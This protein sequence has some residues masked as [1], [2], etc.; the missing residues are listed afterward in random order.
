[1]VG[2]DT[3]AQGGVAPPL[4]AIP[5][6]PG[7]AVNAPASLGDKAFNRK[8]TLNYQKGYAMDEPVMCVD[9]LADGVNN[10]Q[11]I[12]TISPS[13]AAGT[14]YSPL[15]T[16]Y[17]KWVEFDRKVLRWYGYFKE[18]VTESATENYRV[19]K[20]VVCYYLEDDTISVT[21]PKQDNSGLPQG[22]FIRRHRIEKPGGGYFGIPDFVVGQS[23][24]MYGRVFQIVDADSHTRSYLAGQG[25]DVSG[26]EAYPNDPFETKKLSMTHGHGSP[27]AGQPVES[28]S[29][30]FEATMG[31][32][33]GNEKL[34]QFM[35]HSRKVLRFYCVWDDRR[36]M[37]GDRRPYRLH[38]FLEDDSVEILEVH[39]GNSGRDPFPVFLKRG[40]LPKDHM[41]TKAG[42][43]A[44]S[45]CFGPSDFR[46]GS[47]IHIYG[48]DFFIHDCDDFTRQWYQE[49]MGCTD[50]EMGQIPISEPIPP[51]PRPALPPYNGFGSHEDSAQSCINLV[52]KPPKRDFYKLMNKDKI[53][54]R[55][56]CRFVETDTHKLS[57]A[58]RE[59]KFVLSYF[60]ADDTLSVFEPPQ[61]NTGITGG[62]YLER[63]K[64]F[65]ASSSD[66]YIEKDLYVGAVL[67]IHHR[68]FE[69]EEADEY[70]YQYMENNRHIYMMAD[71]E[72]AL[73]AVRAQIHGRQEELKTALIASDPQGLG[74][75]TIEQFSGALAQAGVQ[76]TKHQ[77]ISI[78]RRMPKGQSEAAMLISAFW[79]ALVG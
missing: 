44:K 45:A 32:V 41:T 13:A 39:E 22:V 43:A 7:Y 5:K 19:R 60:L 1:M 30:F 69:L 34:K 52:P 65:K 26:A 2:M 58:D 6:L 3:R 61:R 50:A 17:P 37:Y 8:Q 72:S 54:L 75:L 28:L 14:A 15:N 62:K 63:R 18:A 64:V 71:W 73:K 49:N 36:A 59:R 33:S 20:I 38:Y 16:T 21:E 76:L 57:T 55:F 53:I 29:K 35:V 51:V 24:T 11:L 47:Y 48:R 67:P 9:P 27:K 42:S 66:T 40:P 10:K 70:T 23:V 74:E 77:A 46:I 68:T 78:H 31:K 4:V 12:K 79:Q 56:G 25:S